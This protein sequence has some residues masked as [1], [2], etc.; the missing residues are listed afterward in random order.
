MLTKIAVSGAHGTGKT[1]ICESLQAKYAE[2][3]WFAI[4]REVPR[5]IVGA[6]NDSDFF[7]RGNNTIDRQLLIFLYQLEEERVRSD[8]KRILFCDRSPIDHLA[9]TLANH[10]SYEGTPEY[11]ALEKLIKGWLMTFDRIYKVPIE[12]AL[13]DDGVRES[14]LIFQKEID[15][16]IDRLYEKLGITCPEISGSVESR[17][18][19][20]SDYIESKL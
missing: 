10:P 17:T 16:L 1:T 7:K 14:D 4:S 15:K 13:E 8:Q 2:A 12:F 6:V 19:V 18:A 9:Y 11:Q 3:D 5:I 20:L